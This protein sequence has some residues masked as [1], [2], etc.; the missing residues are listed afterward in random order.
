[1]TRKIVSKGIIAVDVVSL[2]YFD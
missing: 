2:I 1:M